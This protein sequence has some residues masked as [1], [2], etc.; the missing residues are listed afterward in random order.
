MPSS[1]VLAF[2]ANVD[3]KT[4]RANAPS[5]LTCLFELQ[6]K[7]DLSRAPAAMRTNVCLVFDCSGSMVDAKRETAIGAAKRIVDTIHERHRISLV[8]FASGARLLVNNAHSS[9]DQRDAIKKQIDRIR[10]F[11]RGTTNLAEGLRRGMRVVS[12]EPSD[13][14]VMVILS[15]G[16]ADDPKAAEQAALRATAHGIQLFAVGIG[17]DYHAER[18]L[19]MVTPSNGA[20]FGETALANVESTF[21]SLIGRIERFVATNASLV[22]TVAKGVRV[23]EAFKTSPERA[24]VGALTADATGKVAL[25]VGNIE[26]GQTYAFVLSMTV[27]GNAPGTIEILHATLGYDVPAL[28]LRGQEC[29]VGV[30][31][32]YGAGTRESDAEVQAALRAAKIAALTEQLAALRGRR[33]AKKRAEVLELLVEV[34]KAHGDAK[35]AAFYRGLLGEALAGNAL[36]REKLNALVVEASAQR[37]STSDAGRP[38]SKPGKPAK[39]ASLPATF[40]VVLLEAGDSVILLVRELREVTGKPLRDVESIVMDAPSPIREAL[41]L[42]EAKALKRRIEAVGARV[43]V[44][45]R[46]AA[47][48]S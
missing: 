29:E 21:E 27:P 7:S 5:E 2:R 38:S 31:L 3:P 37:Q 46:S 19:R 14:K 23:G 34:C 11:P 40:D 28:R 42:K 8:G 44:R 9:G 47:S 26:H 32:T 48:V 6:S 25:H 15:D 12:A 22:V 10:E 41:S 17:A 18:L 33:D 1:N 4:V 43:E 13:A 24:F 35:G 30:A 36:A 16:G 20:V 45:E 39:R